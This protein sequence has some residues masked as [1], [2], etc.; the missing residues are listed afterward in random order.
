MT[1][2]IQMAYPNAKVL[3]SLVTGATDGRFFRR[4][5]VPAYGAGLLSNKVSL[6]EF[7][8][9]FHGHNERIDVESLSLTTRLWHHVCRDLLG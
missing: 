8:S 2:S 4:R 6:P 1:D 5:G 9:R 7:L 3:P